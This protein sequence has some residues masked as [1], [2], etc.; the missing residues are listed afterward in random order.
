MAAFLNILIGR[1]RKAQDDLYWFKRQSKARRLLTIEGDN[2]FG[3]ILGAHVCACT[4]QRKLSKGAN[5]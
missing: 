1:K 2:Q 5:E 3:I 4:K